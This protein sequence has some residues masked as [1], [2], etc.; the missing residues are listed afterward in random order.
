MSKTLLNHLAFVR[1]VTIKAAQ[2]LSEQALDYIPEGF[3]N[4]IRWNLG[5]ILVIQEKFA[6]QFA[7]EPLQLPDNFERWFAKGT[8]PADWQE[9]QLPTLDELLKLLAEQPVR[10]EKKLHDRLDEQVQ[11]PLTTGN[12]LTLSTIGEFLSYT[13]YHE[14]IHFNAINTLKRFAANRP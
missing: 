7:G 6:F 2:G 8:K 1:Q 11:S 12:G 3:N 13:L 5:H 10:I 4:N 9:E 14:G